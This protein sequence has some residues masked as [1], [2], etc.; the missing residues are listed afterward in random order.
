MI[1]GLALLCTCI[2]L[3]VAGWAWSGGPAPVGMRAGGDVVELSRGVLVVRSDDA[4]GG[5]HADHKRRPCRE[6]LAGSLAP[7]AAFATLS[8]MS[9]IVPPA[10]E[11]L[12][13]ALQSDR[14]P[15]QLL[16]DARFRPPRP[17]AG[18]LR[19]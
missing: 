8:S 7:C 13:F 4:R 5:G 10:P 2:A 9:P 11:R 17:L 1:R 16:D 18:A 19:A 6:R 3:L 15:R 12:V 14:M